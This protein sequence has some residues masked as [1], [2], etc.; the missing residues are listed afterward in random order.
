MHLRRGE[1]YLEARGLY[2]EI[3]S[4]V[5]GAAFEDMRVGSDLYSE[6]MG[7]HDKGKPKLAI[8]FSGGRT[9]AVMTKLLLEKHRDEYSEVKVTFCNTGQEH[10]ATL[11]FVR[12]C[13]DHFGFNTVWLEAVVNPVHGKGIRHRIVDFETAS[14][15][16]EPF[17][18]VIKKYGIPNPALPQCTERLKVEVM[19]DYFRQWGQPGKAYKSAIG[20]RVDE[21]DRMNLS[22]KYIYPLVAQRWTKRMVNDE[23]ASWPF[24]LG[25][26]NDAHGNCVWCW[27]KSFR[28]LYTLAISNPEYFDFPRRMEKE[29]G[30]VKAN[31]SDR[32][33][34]RGSRTANDI[35]REAGETSFRPYTDDDIIYKEFQLDWLDQGAACGDTCEI[36]ADY[37]A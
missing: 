35:L 4:V 19:L 29:Y 31:D 36:G 7:S 10:E 27:K 22:G 15:D 34:F 11:Q 16:G 30:S 18:A 20:I 14:R 1:G 17:E 3:L 6:A 26:P 28:K 33:F 21:A 9:S 23:V 8:S 13:D 25:I 2:G 5:V 12:D 37:E 32:T 24:D